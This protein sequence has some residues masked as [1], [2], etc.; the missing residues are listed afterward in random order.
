MPRL[1]TTDPSSFSQPELVKINHIDLDWG[2]NFTD[3][4]IS[5][6]AQIQFVILAK[7]IEEIVSCDYPRGQFNPIFSS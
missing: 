5:G 6:S 7:F 2:V 4:V 1:S 3:K